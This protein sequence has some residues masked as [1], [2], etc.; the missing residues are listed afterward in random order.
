MV[1]Q[2]L[3][4]DPRPTALYCFNN[5]LAALVIEELVSRGIDVPRAL[6]V[7]GGGGEQVADLA[8]NQ[9]DW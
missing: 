1:D 9:A 3:A 6:S 2:W 5:S 7:A 4:L 8:G